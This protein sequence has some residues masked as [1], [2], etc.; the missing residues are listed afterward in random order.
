MELEDEPP[1]PVD[2]CS[3]LGHTESLVMKAEDGLLRRYLRH[4]N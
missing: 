4:L 1:D 3:S 2:R